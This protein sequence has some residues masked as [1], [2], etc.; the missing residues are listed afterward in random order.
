M[1]RTLS[2]FPRNP[3]P[4]HALAACAAACALVLAPAAMAAEAPAPSAQVLQL[5][6]GSGSYVTDDTGTLSQSQLNQLDA[7]L[8]EIA[9]EGG[10]AHVYLVDNLGDPATWAANQYQDNSSSPNFI[11][12]GIG[13]GDRHWSIATNKQGWPPAAEST[14][15]DA[16]RAR[17]ESGDIAGAAQIFADRVQAETQTAAA[18]EPRT[19]TGAG[20]GTGTVVEQVPATDSGSGVAGG[21]SLVL[22]LALL[23]GGFFGVRKMLKKGKSTSH[24]SP[25]A[26][27][28]GGG[29]KP[30]T[31]EQ[32]RQID[33]SDITAL[34]ALPFGILKTRAEEE[35]NS[36][37]SLNRRA[38]Q[39]LDI[40][41]DEFGMERTR[42]FTAAMNTST[43]T[44]QQA[45]S[46]YNNANTAGVP[47]EA[48]A[49]AFARVVSQCGQAD[50]ALAAQ[51]EDFQKMRDLLVRAPER[52]EELTRKTVAVTTRIPQADQTLNKLKASYSEQVLAP[53]ADNIELAQAHLKHADGLIDSARELIK[54][55]AGSQGGLI[56]YIRGAEDGLQQAD[57]LLDT[58]DEAGPKLAAATTKIDDLISEIRQETA[59]LKQLLDNPRNSGLVANKEDALADFAQVDKVLAD[60]AADKDTD[61]LG[62]YAQ[63][64]DL[65]A[66]LDEVI[67][68]VKQKASTHSRKQELFDQMLPPTTSM[69]DGVNDLVG[70]RP[71]VIG[72]DTRT[73]LARAQQYRA[74]ALNEQSSNLDGAITHLRQANDAARSAY[75]AARRDL[76]DYN[77]RM[78]SNYRGGSG[79][80]FGTFIAGALVGD[81]MSD[82]FR[83]SGGFGGGGGFSGGSFG[84]GGFSGG[85]FGGGGGGF[86]GGSF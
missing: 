51:S 70:S 86:S 34:R 24:T 47:R 37:D 14:V 22:V 43:T 1:S 72:A 40:A 32:A 76:D 48:Q 66:R 44:L 28:S 35:L 84:G 81:M 55:P 57:H 31:L 36:T 85:S 9:A 69:I 38:K 78:R 8:G 3:R 83:G 64:T 49:E 23:A 26:I 29:G 75:A 27:A 5:A 65:D 11:A 59:E 46:T 63:L 67:A 10:D 42:R 39:E 79:G 53:V 20:T 58:V 21:F 60:C 54:K 61:P 56:D 41:R 17:L 2:P 80:G 50:Q 16:V 33:P 25:Q 15:S 12:L 19:N 7:V 6:A 4:V 73:A 74:M 30:V 13:V 77:S 71:T 52:V 62:T 68:T 82:M 45:F 18:E